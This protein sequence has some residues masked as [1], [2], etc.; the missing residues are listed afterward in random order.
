MME[1]WICSSVE[2]GG[3]GKVVVFL[4]RARMSAGVVFIGTVKW[5]KVGLDCEASGSSCW[6]AIN[7]VAEGWKVEGFVVYVDGLVVFMGVGG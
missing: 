1:K 5:T 6:V 2:L 7:C 3:K 4:M